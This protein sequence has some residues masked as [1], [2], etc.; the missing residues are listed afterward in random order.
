[1]CFDIRFWLTVCLTFSNWRRRVY[2][3]AGLPKEK[4]LMHSL[5]FVCASAVSLQTYFLQVR[6]AP[7][8]RALV[9]FLTGSIR[10]TI[11][12]RWSMWLWWIP[13]VQERWYMRQLFSSFRCWTKGFLEQSVPC[14]RKATRVSRFYFFVKALFVFCCLR[15]QCNSDLCEEHI[16][17]VSVLLKNT[18]FQLQMDRFWMLRVQG[19]WWRVC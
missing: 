11:T 18:S 13:G 4:F 14:Q 8:I 10:V 15:L 1:M 19:L 3:W 9:F 7:K 2:S 5:R 6:L 17:N 12:L 16:W